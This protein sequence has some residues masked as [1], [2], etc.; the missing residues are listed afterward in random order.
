MIFMAA[1]M[2]ALEVI[3]S[4]S[5]N[6]RVYRAPYTYYGFAAC[7]VLAMVNLF[8]LTLILTSDFN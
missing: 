7:S 1:S 5:G 3:G 2:D 8:L 6:P 4:L